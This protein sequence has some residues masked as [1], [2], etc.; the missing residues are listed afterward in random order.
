[1]GIR[2]ARLQTFETETT[3][4]AP[5][6][7]RIETLTI[8]GVALWRCGARCSGRIRSRA[9]RWTENDLVIGFRALVGTWQMIRSRV[10]QSEDLTGKIIELPRIRIRTLRFEDFIVSG[11]LC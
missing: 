10:D 1:M 7:V 9:A 3:P 4:I 5:V 11:I 8:A 2:T 6:H